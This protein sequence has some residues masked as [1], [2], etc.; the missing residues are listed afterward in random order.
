MKNFFILLLLF[1]S[2]YSLFAEISEQLFTPLQI[3][4]VLISDPGNKGDTSSGGRQLGS[5]K[6]NFFLGKYEITAN[7]YCSFLKAVASH[8]DPHHL[9]KKE[10]GEDAAVACIKQTKLPNE[11]FSYDLIDQRGTFPITYVTLR[12]AQRF[13]NWLENNC[14]DAD[15]DPD[16][17]AGSTERGAYFITQNGEEE[18]VSFN[19]KAHYWI[20][21][22]DEWVKAAYYKGKGI[23]SGYWMYPTQHDSAPNSGH[24]D[25]S[26]EANYK[27]LANHWKQSEQNSVLIPVDYF[28]KTC[29]FYGACDMGGNV[30]EWTCNLNSENN[31]T[32]GSSLEAVVRGGSWKSQYSIWLD[33][34]LMRTA[35]PP[36][37]GALT[38]HNFIGF[39]IA[40]VPQEDEYAQEQDMD[41]CCNNHTSTE[42]YML[43]TAARGLFI[44]CPRTVVT[45]VAKFFGYDAC[46]LLGVDSIASN[47]L[48]VFGAVF[49][50]DFAGY[51]A[52]TAGITAASYLLPSVWSLIQDEFFK[53]NSQDN[54]SHHDTASIDITFTDI[55]Q[56]A[57][58]A[59]IGCG[60]CQLNL[61]FTTL[62]TFLGTA[63]IDSSLLTIIENSILDLQLTEIPYVPGWIVYNSVPVLIELGL[64]LVFLEICEEAYY[65][66]PSFQDTLLQ[67]WY[68]L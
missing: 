34:E 32:L 11:T 39:R 24:G 52:I 36:S 57:M 6:K 27:T 54:K 41:G 3:P 7:Q 12:D 60:M 15:T 19:P 53:T 16:L 35:T 51:L 22:E 13:C 25:L 18:C 21:T 14:P 48:R 20:P 9:Y 65:Y 46:S 33:N 30:A 56:S 50:V 58:K 42:S 2:P 28:S 64:F 40:A 37:Y 5:V 17:L 45:S 55:L 62:K 1:L 26:N 61:F 23:N 63:G 8:N 44:G 67:F 43:W 59:I 47:S 31:I 29:S 4:A 66:W 68:A 10:M 38:A 49:L